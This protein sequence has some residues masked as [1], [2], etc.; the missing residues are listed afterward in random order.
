M[1]LEY[2]AKIGR[3]AFADVWLAKDALGRS[4]AVKFFNDTAPTQA[5]MNALNHAKAL[6]R[7]NHPAV[8]RVIALERQ[9]HPESNTDCLAI[10][11]EYVPGSNL[12]LHKDPLATDLALAIIRDLAMAIEAIHSCGM[13]HGDLHD[14]NIMLTA[15][16]A[17][18]VDILCTHSLAEVGTRTAVRTRDD[19]MRDLAKLFRQIVAK[20][21]Q[22]GSRLAE[23]YYQA[24]TASKSAVE[25]MSIFA[26]LLASLNEESALAAL[27]Y[28]IDTDDR[29]TGMLNDDGVSPFDD[30]LPFDG[31]D[32][33]DAV[34]PFDD[35]PPFDGE[36]SGDTV[37]PFDDALPSDSEEN[38]R[39]SNPLQGVSVNPTPPKATENSVDVLKYLA[40]R[41]SRVS[42][43]RDHLTKQRWDRIS[44]KAPP[45]LIKNWIEAV[46]P[47]PSDDGAVAPLFAAMWK[48][49]QSLEIVP[50][51]HAL[52]GR[53]DLK[54]LTQFYL[55]KRP[56]WTCLSQQQAR[57]VGPRVRA[58]ALEFGWAD[59]AWE[60]SH[61]LAGPLFE[62]IWDVVSDLNADK[63]VIDKFELRWWSGAGGA[64]DAGSP[65]IFPW[66][67]AD[68]LRFS[69]YE[70]LAARW[71]TAYSRATVF[72]ERIPKDNTTADSLALSY[73][74][75]NHVLW[76][77]SRHMSPK[78]WKWIVSHLFDSAA[79][80]SRG[81]H[82]W[83]AWTRAVPLLAAPESGLSPDVAS[84]ILAATNLDD[85]MRTELGDLRR[86][87]ARACL[88]RSE[89]TGMLATIDADYSDHPWVMQVEER[90][91]HE[92]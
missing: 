39:F 64:L 14:G 68:L 58:R 44:S 4:V 1:E 81:N 18:V 26:D 63:M 6:A 57:S 86:R 12:S 16:G 47:L 32:S 17:K 28:A 92:R 41:L 9:C 51:V 59:G 20:T 38:N 53:I 90:A 27:Q 62:L 54:A 77:G 83:A 42:A 15:S 80:A 55:E 45:Q 78:D 31:E 89:V 22:D 24:S 82:A 52:D 76:H 71:N 74:E 33:G 49:A 10:I 37:Y 50:H 66:P 23:A 73:V 34:S 79:R 25:M 30:V 5:E 69:E 36:D 35:V 7:V 61:L 84:T 46:E 40:L 43:V 48:E 67:A 19:D 91:M 85:T 13:V 88:G 3:G 11:M 29:P 87:R 65:L 2:D 60:P 8:V 72:H 56:F 21:G 75:F 70:Q